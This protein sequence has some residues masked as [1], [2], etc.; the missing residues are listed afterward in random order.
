MFVKKQELFVVATLMAGIL[1][2][3]VGLDSAEDDLDIE[4][5]HY[6]CKKI[7]WKIAKKVFSQFRKCST[8]LKEKYPNDKKRAEYLQVVKFLK[9]HIF[10]RIL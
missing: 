5:Y 8:E 1:L 7:V 2:C 6:D 9:I 10:V 4:D 3:M